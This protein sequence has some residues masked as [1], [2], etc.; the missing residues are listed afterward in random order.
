MTENHHPDKE[1]LD[2]IERVLK[3][4]ASDNKLL[5]KLSQTVPQSR[6]DFQNSLEDSLIAQLSA[7]TPKTDSGDEFMK[8]YD[9]KSKRKKNKSSRLP[10]TLV[11]AVIAIA[12]IGGLIL[13]TSLNNST[14][15]YADS[16]P[17]GMALTTTQLINEAIATGG[18][19]TIGI[20]EVLPAT[21]TPTPVPDNFNL[22]ATAIANIEDER[23]SDD[24]TRVV[25]ALRDIELNETITDDM[26]TTVQYDTEDAWGLA[27]DN[28]GTF[29]YN[30]E[31][32]VIGQRASTFIP[33]HNPITSNNVTETQNCEHEELELAHLGC[34]TVDFGYRI[35]T[36]TTNNSITDATPLILP[37]GIR[38]DVITALQL[39]EIGDRLRIVDEDDLPLDIVPFI[40]MTAIVSNAILLNVE[41]R[42]DDMTV[43]L[44]LSEDNAVALE[45][46]LQSNTPIY[47]RPHVDNTELLFDEEIS[48]SV[49]P[50]TENGLAMVSISLTQVNTDTVVNI[51]DIFDI[52]FSILPDE[53][54]LLS[55]IPTPQ[56]GDVTNLNSLTP[57]SGNILEINDSSVIYVGRGS[58]DYPNPSGDD[59][60]FMAISVNPDD[61][62]IVDWYASNGAN[63]NL[64]PRN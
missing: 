15:P 25:I 62:W 16:L 6:S 49:Y 43:T 9:E 46:I 23:T 8:L 34:S 42:G 19:S 30:N 1:M 60:L 2:E 64:R 63:F 4:Q 20:L 57:Y 48:S 53:T 7:T 37:L 41:G 11:A 61:A 59:S 26:I 14:E 33:A 50:L 51:G 36:F 27:E 38:V 21:F 29:Y 45:H 47:F 31:G 12:L 24:F 28:Q 22:T 39:I 5:T 56:A 35:M 54:D 17:E 58:E 44:A 13:I 32:I 40:R 55:A 52:Q 10:F 18:T 3:H